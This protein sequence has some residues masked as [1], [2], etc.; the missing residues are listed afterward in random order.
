MAQL[1]ELDDRIAKCNKILGEN[2]NS[3][4]FAALAEA[5]RKTGEVDKAFRI[6]QNG[7]KIHPDYGSAH[8][9]MAKINLDKGLYDWAEMEVTKAVELDGESHAT[10]VLMAE[11]FIYK[12]E[13]ARATKILNQLQAIDP[14][15]SHVSKLLE[16]A[17]KI[18]LESPEKKTVVSE[19]IAGAKEAPISS[20]TAVSESDEKISIGG[21]LDSISS[22]NGIEGVLLVN[23]EGLV[24]DA[25]WDSR[26][27]AELYG[28]VAKDIEAVIKSQIEISHFG[29]YENILVEAEDLIINLLPIDN[30][31]LVIRANKHINLGTLRMK[32]SGLMSKLS[33]EIS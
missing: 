30:N 6:C 21:M 11:I 17:R 1:T 8:M 9:V 32:L 10:M 29:S 13:F 25:R 3:Q 20:Q 27:P 4:I 19:P 28:A 18:P 5:Y 24:A 33:L 14:R 23:G 7:L 16:M 26:Q 2:P 15:N 22:I 12:G 31:L